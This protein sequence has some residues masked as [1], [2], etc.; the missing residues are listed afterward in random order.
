MRR[1]VKDQ[2]ARL[3]AQGLQAP[4]PRL[5]FRGQEPL[6]HEPVGRLAG[7][8][9]RGQHRG[10]TGYGDHANALGMGGRDQRESGVADRRRARVADQCHVIATQQPLDQLRYTVG[11][12]VLVQR[13]QLRLDP[14]ALQHASRVPGVL[15]GHDRDRCKHL[16]GAHAEIIEVANGGR[17]DIERPRFD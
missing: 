8:R 14:E 3:V 17:D 7:R 9:Q 6:E 11:L 1:F 5:A 4:A 13:Q 15:G 16:A 12:V 10:G 2:R